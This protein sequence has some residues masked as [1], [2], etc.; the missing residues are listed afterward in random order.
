MSSRDFVLTS[1]E[2]DLKVGRVL[3]VLFV[4]FMTL[5]LCMRLQRDVSVFA[6]LMAVGLLVLGVISVRKLVKDSQ[7]RWVDGLELA[8]FILILWEMPFFLI[9]VGL[10]KFGQI[11]RLFVSSDR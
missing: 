3:Q 9:Q 5:L 7:P 8:S 1:D 10:L 6:F 4:A 11:R 2:T